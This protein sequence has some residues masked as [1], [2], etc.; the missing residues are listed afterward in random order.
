MLQQQR[1]DIVAKL[2]EKQKELHDNI[3]RIANTFSKFDGELLTTDNFR[4]TITSA[5]ENIF[6]AIKR[7][8]NICWHAGMMVF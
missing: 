5:Q 8:H 2:T 1:G 7:R 6:S 4:Y 3:Y